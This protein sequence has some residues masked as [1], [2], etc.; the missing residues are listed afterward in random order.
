MRYL[1]CKLGWNLSVMK[2]TL[3]LRPKFFHPYLPMRCSGV[4]E[5]WN[6]ALSAHSR[7]GVEVWSKSVFNEGYF[8]LEKER[9]FRQYLDFLCR[10]IPETSNFALPADAPQVRQI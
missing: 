6:L 8:T 7:E 1:K 10:G 9:I 2:G 5:T 3:L 4:T